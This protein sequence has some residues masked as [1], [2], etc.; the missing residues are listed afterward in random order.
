MQESYFLGVDPSC[1]PL[2]CWGTFSS[3]SSHIY[4]VVVSNNVVSNLHMPGL[5]MEVLQYQ[6]F[7]KTCLL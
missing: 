7:T 1:L 6:L 3:A 5:L 4:A 2:C